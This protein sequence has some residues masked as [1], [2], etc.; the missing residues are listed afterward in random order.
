MVSSVL[1]AYNM[2]GKYSIRFSHCLCF[3]SSKKEYLLVSIFLQTPSL[4]PPMY[5]EYPSVERKDVTSKYP[6]ITKLFNIQCHIW[7]FILL[8][9]SADFYIFLTKLFCFL[10]LCSTDKDK[11]GNLQD[12]G[13]KNN[14]YKQNPKQTIGSY[15]THNRERALEQFNPQRTYG[16]QEIMGRLCEWG[17]EREGKSLACTAMSQKWYEI[18]ECHDCKHD[19]WTRHIEKGE[20][21]VHLV[22]FGFPSFFFNCPVFRH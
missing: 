8:S 19:E 1:L 9:I 4:L 14:I 16:R 18:V 7:G 5:S 22:F 3:Y 12:S 2:L 17:S 13:N 11:T 15:R 6:F 10:I 20:Y 21:A